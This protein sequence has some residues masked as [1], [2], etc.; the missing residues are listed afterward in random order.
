[1]QRISV[2][3]TE[4]IILATADL[5]ELDR[6]LTIYTRGYGKILARAISARKKESKLKGLLES[7]SRANFLLAKSKTID[8]VT[9][10]ET[11]EGYRYLHGN[12]ESLAYA[13][14]FAELV[15]KLVIGQ[16]RDENLWRL[17]ARAFEV[18]N[19][20]RTDLPKIKELFEQKLLEFLGYGQVSKN[21]KTLDFIQGLAGGEIMAKRF[22]ERLD[23]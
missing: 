14:Y 13:F 18:L 20:K 17:I 22:L 10:V 6:L 16:E 4:G 12:L 7:F 21:K 11:I 3:K 5:G 23:R 19:Q 15:D 8:I 2:Y 9:D 1:M